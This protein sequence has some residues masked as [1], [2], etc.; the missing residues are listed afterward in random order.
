VASC[1][2][3]SGDGRRDV[4][5]GGDERGWRGC[6]SCRWQAFEDGGAAVGRLVEAEEVGGGAHHG[7]FEGNERREEEWEGRGGRGGGAERKR[8]RGE[9]EGIRLERF[10][11]AAG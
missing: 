5:E 11:A 7:G 8:R 10:Y 9:S 2:L 3:A 4:A 1:R 6:G